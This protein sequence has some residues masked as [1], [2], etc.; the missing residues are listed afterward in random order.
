MLAAG[1]L[2]LLE[3]SGLSRSNGKR[4]DS[5]S[6]VPWGQVDLECGMLP[7]QTFLQC[8]IDTRRQVVLGMWLL[9]QMGG[10]LKIFQSCSNLHVYLF[11]PVAIETVVAT[12]PQSG[13]SGRSWEDVCAVGI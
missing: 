11:I 7:A 6:P 9:N 13:L 10:R 1:M 8:A 3:P 12:G 4:L 5:I 2:A